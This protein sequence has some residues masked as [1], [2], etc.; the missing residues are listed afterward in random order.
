MFFFGQMFG[1]VENF[2]IGISTDTINVINVTLCMVVLLI[3]LYLF[4]PL[5]VTLTI[6]KGHSHVKQFQLKNVCSYR[7]KL[8]L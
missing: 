8:K 1:L 2:N 3:E 4:I 7:V 5:S 6:F